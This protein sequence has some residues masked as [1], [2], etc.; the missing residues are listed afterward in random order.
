MFGW[1]KKKSDSASVARE[2]LQII[3]AQQ[4]AQQNSPDYL[5]TL[6]REL[7][8]VIRKYVRVEAEAVTVHVGRE[9]NQEI[10]ELNVVLPEGADPSESS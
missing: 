9:G 10:L 3:V 8:E 6:K 7:L 1:L 2:R 5:P 4:R